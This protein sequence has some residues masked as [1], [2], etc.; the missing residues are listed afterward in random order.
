MSEYICVRRIKKKYCLVCGG[1]VWVGGVWLG[2]GVV[3]VGVGWGVVVCGGW[4]EG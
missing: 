2:V 4:V 1:G 3:G